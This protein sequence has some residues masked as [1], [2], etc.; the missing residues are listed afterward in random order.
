[1]RPWVT[2]SGVKKHP[3]FLEKSTSARQDLW[4]RCDQQ[5]GQSSQSF[6]S[7]T[8]IQISSRARERER[9]KTRSLSLP[10]WGASSSM[11]ST[12]NHPSSTI[13]VACASNHGADGK[14]KHLCKCAL[15]YKN[16][17]L[18][19]PATRHPQF[20]F[21][22]SWKNPPCRPADNSTPRL[23]PHAQAIQ[24]QSGLMEEREIE[25]EKT[26]L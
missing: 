14:N 23:S 26:R 4:I 18:I 21:A 7:A 24:H 22:S 2:R 9:V 20:T 25:T 15:R 10:S 8:R 17:A 13:E 19:H 1:M 6:I 11:S 3:T 5:S 16:P 12:R